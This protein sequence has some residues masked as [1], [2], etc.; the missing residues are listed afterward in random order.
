MKV[1]RIFAAVAIVTL[2]FTGFVFA[3]E[4]YIVLWGEQTEGWGGTNAKTDGNK[5]TLEEAATII[6]VEGNAKGYCIWSG[7]KSVLCGGSA[8]N[9][10]IVN[11]ILPPGTYTVLPGLY[12][13][14]KA[15][16]T[17][18]LQYNKKLIF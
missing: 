12:E 18:Y 10:S 11:E 16:V 2:I 17:I 8:K 1:L 14:S 5:V 3:E 6:K 9:K 7:G 15:T 13:Q 4:D